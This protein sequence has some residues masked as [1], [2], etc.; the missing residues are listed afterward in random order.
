[1]KK[2]I[3]SLAVLPLLTVGV[4]S[5]S[6]SAQAYELV[7]PPPNSNASFAPASI[8]PAGVTAFIRNST[9]VP[10]GRV[11]ILDWLPYQDVNQPLL[12]NP[13]PVLSGT[14]VGFCGTA[15]GGTNCSIPGG[16]GNQAW[17]AVF[18]GTTTP[19]PGVFSPLAFVPGLGPGVLGEN[20]LLADVVLPFFGVPVGPIEVN[21]PWATPF[22]L[23]DVSNGYVTPNPTN[24]AIALKPINSVDT[25]TTTT[26]KSIRGTNIPGGSSVEFV[27]DGYWN[28]YN[29][30]SSMVEKYQGSVAL[31]Q[32]LTDSI[33]FL[34]DQAA[35]DNGITRSYNGTT[36]VFSRV[37]EPSALGGLAAVALG[38]T[39]LLRKR[40]KQQ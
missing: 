8:L 28:I 38:A 7:P 11:L 23:L 9:S 31:S 30:G 34:A 1:M 33:E 22:T 14:G 32:V 21:I 29:P 4:M 20:G 12:P 36:N 40:Q 5:G 18:I 35:T 16:V 13:G 3:G 37:P 24:T 10:S 27:F 15:L 19:V 2:L 39:T 26:L 25:F 17:G 6:G